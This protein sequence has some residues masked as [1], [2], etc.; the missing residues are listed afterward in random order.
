M[1]LSP[2]QQRGAHLVAYKQLMAVRKMVRQQSGIVRQWKAGGA[3]IGNLRKSASAAS[4]S[5]LELAPDGA[6]GWKRHAVFAAA[7]AAAFGIGIALGRK[8]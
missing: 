6:E 8:R 7:C 3:L 1:R 5:V 2:S 4:T